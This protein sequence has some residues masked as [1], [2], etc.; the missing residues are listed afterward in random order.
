MAKY[1]NEKILCEMYE[2]FYWKKPD[3]ENKNI[4]LEIHSMMRILWHFDITLSDVGFSINSTIEHFP[5]NDE[6]EVLIDSMKTFVKNNKN[7]EN[8]ESIIDKIQEVKLT[9][10]AIMKIQLASIALHNKAEESGYEFSDF[11]LEVSKIIHANEQVRPDS[12][13]EE[14]STLDYINYDAETI[15]SVLS[16]VKDIDK[17]I[18]KNLPNI[19]ENL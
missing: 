10:K 2:L 1:M 6:I 16:L 9:K 17:D 19:K 5:W 18:D 3:F 7:N 8:N 15:D 4:E 12:E 13:G 11:V 14:I